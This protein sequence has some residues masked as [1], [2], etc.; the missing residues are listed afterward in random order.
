[1]RPAGQRGTLHDPLSGGGPPIQARQAGVHAGFIEKFEVRC[2]Q[3]SDLSS[4]GAPLAFHPRRVPLGGVERLFLRDSFSRRSSR[5]IMLS[6]ECT[7]VTCSTRSHNSSRVRSGWVLTA[8]RIT[9][10]AA[11]SLRTGPPAWGRGAQLPVFRQRAS[12]RS[13]DGWL[14]WNRRAAWG[15]VHSPLATH[16]TARSRRSTE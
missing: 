7:R 10:S 8:E 15:T 11:A 4:K 13:S 9:R 2:I 12:Q 14:T 3:A 5:H 1:M 16:W 6:L